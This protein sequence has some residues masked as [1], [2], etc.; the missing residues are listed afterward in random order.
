MGT[1]TRERGYT[2]HGGERVPKREPR[3]SPENQRR[4]RPLRRLRGG[5]FCV[6]SKPQEATGKRGPNDSGVP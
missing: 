4:Q 6:P 5:I 1:P 3:A 2:P